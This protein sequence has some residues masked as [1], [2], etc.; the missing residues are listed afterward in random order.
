M[1]LRGLA[2]LILAALFALNFILPN[3]SFSH[4]GPENKV[5]ADRPSQLAIGRALPP[6]ELLG[7]DGRTYSREDL[8]GHRVLLTF[9]RSV[10]W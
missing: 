4:R 2:T 7:F 6:L 1:I 10:D 8:R 3:S 9:E 5:R